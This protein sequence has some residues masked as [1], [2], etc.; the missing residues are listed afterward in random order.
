MASCDKD[1]TA[2]RV[3]EFNSTRIETGSSKELPFVTSQQ[4]NDIGAAL[5]SPHRQ[6]LEKSNGKLIIINN[7]SGIK[8]FEVRLKNIV[9]FHTNLKT[10]LAAK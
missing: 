1:F 3:Q 10:Y 9:K 4:L 5:F 6:S 7:S 8:F 2:F